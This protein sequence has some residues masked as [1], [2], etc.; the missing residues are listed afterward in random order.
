MQHLAE[1]KRFDDVV[2]ERK[3]NKKK[4]AVVAILMTLVIAIVGV[5]YCFAE[6]FAYKNVRIE[7]NCDGESPY[8]EEDVEKRLGLVK[9]MGL[10]SIDEDT[11]NTRIKYNLTYI[12]SASVS[13]RI[14]STIVLK[15]E[16]LAKPAYYTEVGGDLYILGDDL[17]VLEM[18]DDIEKIEIN[19]LILL[20]LS[21]VRKCIE[22]ET[23]GIDEKTAEI[24]TELRNILQE[25][26]V[27][28]DIVRIDIKSEFN[29][30]LLCT[31]RFAVKLGDNTNLETKILLM[32]TV[33]K[34]KKGLNDGGTIDV[35]DD[36]ARE[37]V[38]RRYG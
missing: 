15:I 19:S 25:N 3:K 37:A 35:S 11:M 29:I 27:F 8:T 26:E 9:G 7:S 14:P 38:F 2:A 10:Y 31:S 17:K 20:E 23:L 18:T 33:I 32:K 22:G 28:S 4:S 34:D 13:R 5:Y 24:L 1:K 36:A 21:D 30:N 12:D 6:L 16:K